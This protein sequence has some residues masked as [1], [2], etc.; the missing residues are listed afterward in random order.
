[1][2]QLAQAVAQIQV[3]LAQLRDEV[4]ELRRELREE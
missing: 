4:V 1:M 3:D 2:D